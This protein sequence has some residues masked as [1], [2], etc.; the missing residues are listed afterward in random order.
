MHVKKKDKNDKKSYK[1]MSVLYNIS[2]VYRRRM[3][4]NMD[5]YFV[6]VLFQFQC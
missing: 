2:K 3:E 4:E 6:N 1:P 5:D